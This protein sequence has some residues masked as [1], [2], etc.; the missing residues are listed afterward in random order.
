MI[1]AS[2]ADSFLEDCPPW[3]RVFRDL[4][5]IVIIWCEV[6]VVLI[7]DY[8][9][10]RLSGGIT[11]DLEEYSHMLSTRGCERV[12]RLPIEACDHHTS[13]LCDIFTL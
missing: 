2:I 9:C 3:D 8:D 13:I 4:P 10:Y 7:D 6:I 5:S 1:I 12:V 11:L